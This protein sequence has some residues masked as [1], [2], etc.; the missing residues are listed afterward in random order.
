MPPIND[1]KSF[2]KRLRRQKQEINL[3]Y[4]YHGFN[5]FIGKTTPRSKNG[6]RHRYMCN[7][8]IYIQQWSLFSEQ[9]HGGQMFFFLMVSP[10]VFLFPLVNTINKHLLLKSI[11]L[12]STVFGTRILMQWRPFWIKLQM[13]AW[14]LTRFNWAAFKNNVRNKFWCN[15][16]N[17]FLKNHNA[18]RNFLV[19][20]R[21]ITV[22][23]SIES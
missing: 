15:F 1:R 8:P 21:T 19:L 3:I 22:S 10:L 20:S 12:R 7:P 4:Y 2:F 9:S 14:W 23:F 16:Q 5:L 11:K 18:N 13:F 17:K 6:R